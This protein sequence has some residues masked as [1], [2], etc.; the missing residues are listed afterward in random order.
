[1]QMKAI[2]M[3]QPGE[4]L[5]MGVFVG[6]HGVEGNPKVWLV[7]LEGAHSYTESRGAMVRVWPLGVEL[8]G[9]LWAP[10]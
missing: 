3:V 1:M 5:D 2:E 9:C 8:I 4:R 7:L 10:R 6:F